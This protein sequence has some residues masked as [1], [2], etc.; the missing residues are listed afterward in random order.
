[1][2]LLTLRDLQ[3]R[4]SRVLVVTLLVTLVL[5]LLYL[6]TG[7]INQLQNEPHDAV[8][9]IG[10]D[11][12]TVAEGVSGPFTSVS[13]LPLEGAS[14]R[15]AG[16]QPAVVSRG[17]LVDGAGESAEVVIFGH[18]P[19]GLGTPTIESGAAASNDGQA[20]VD[21]SLGL[22]AGDTIVVGGRSLS[23][24][25]TTSGTT[26]LAGLPFVFVEL[27]VAQDLSFNSR[28]VVSTYLTSGP[29]PDQQ[30]ETTVLSAE[31]VADDA[32]GP[33]ES[34][35]ASIDLI[36]VLLWIVAAIVVGAVV[37]LSA[38]E[39]SRDFAVLKAVGAKGRS[40]AAGLAL[41]AVIIA[42]IGAGLAAVLATLIQPVFPLAVT[43]PAAAYWQIPLAAAIV[44]L[45][46]AVF[47]VR[48]VDRTDPAAA[49]GG[50][51][52]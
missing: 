24:S 28:A 44:G 13:V 46:A 8:A 14:D 30:S 15:G 38:L 52:A 9:V 1:M 11:Y 41:Q 12:W 34:A 18:V 20:V 27:G 22:G 19:G 10:A 35:I 40:L 7:L 17:S 48:K 2:L 39:R 5:T 25:G 26:V 31:E 32:L 33:I 6:M 23:V 3:H 50:A 36:R 4:F 42:V 29:L 37:Y 47:G 43:V 51:A 21:S 16:T 45:V 49:F